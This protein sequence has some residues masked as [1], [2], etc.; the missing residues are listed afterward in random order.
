M[1][2]ISKMQI[3]DPKAWSGL[4]RSAHLGYL[5]MKDPIMINKV[6]DRLFERNYGADNI[7]SLMDQFPTKYIDDD[8][9]FQWALQ[10]SDER[11][12]PLLQAI[13]LAGTA[14]AAGDRFG[15]GRGM[16]RM[17]FPERYFEVTSV[18][19]GM[20]PDNFSLRVVE[21]PTSVG[22]NWS[23]LVQL[24]TGDDSLFV[25]AEDLAPGTRWSEDYG[26]AEQELSKRGSGVHHTSPF[27]L[28]NVCSLIR[29]NYE[30]PGNMITAGKNRP[31]AFAFIDQNGKTQTRWIDK[32]GWD[33]LVQ[34]RRDK[35]RLYLHGKSNRLPDGTYGNKGESGN[36]MRSGYGLYEMMEG[37]NTLYYN[38]FF[39]DKLGNFA[40]DISVGKLAEDSRKFILSTGERGAYKFH[41]S[42]ENRAGALAAAWLRSDHNF[43]TVD[44][45]M[46]LDEGQ[47]ASYKFV[48]G[49]EFKVMIDPMK[50][51]PVRNKLPHPEGGLASSYIYD[52]WDFGSVKGEPNIQKVAVKDQEEFF[53]YIPGMRDPF[54]PGGLGKNTDP[55][56]TVSPVDGYSV[57]KMFIGGIQLRNP[58]R[59]GR[60]IPT[61]LQ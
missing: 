24:V 53:R 17:I 21:E 16:F 54:T 57:W 3:V 31:L 43:K 46:Q 30:V 19:V 20:Y 10:G 2:R 6:I 61:V 42:M 23:Y 15:L 4:T 49:I 28:E 5:G 8:V 12:I 47:F 59:T 29:K 22:V 27:M 26:Q 39:A 34:F 58:L 11:N 60:M 55:T 33:F 48:N 25:P 35:A 50:D 44:G 7:V 38:D 45:K 52:I 13:D 56:M 18:I 51:D 36:T 41:Q 9:P 32:L 14:V 1:N 37:G 40:L